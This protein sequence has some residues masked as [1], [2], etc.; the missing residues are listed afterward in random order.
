MKVSYIHA[1]ER[2]DEECDRETQKK[3]EYLRK[4]IKNFEKEKEKLRKH[5]D[6]FGGKKFS[7]KELITNIVFAILIVILLLLQAFFKVLLDFM[8]IELAIFLVS[9]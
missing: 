3:Q 9:A 4:D 5:I 7:S 1:E 8:S 6:E 2:S